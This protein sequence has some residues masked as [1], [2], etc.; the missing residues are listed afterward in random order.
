MSGTRFC[1]GHSCWC[2]WAGGQGP[3]VPRFDVFV[4][5]GPLMT[6]SP[7]S[8]KQHQS[9]WKP[10]VGFLQ[11]MFRSDHLQHLLGVYLPTALNPLDKL[12]QRLK[13]QHQRTPVWADPIVQIH[14]GAA[15]ISDYSTSWHCDFCVKHG[16]KYSLSKN[17]E[18][19]TCFDCES[20]NPC[21]SMLLHLLNISEKMAMFD[22]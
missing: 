8:L 14:C 3:L 4:K 15:C 7:P 2:S 16:A 19:K 22:G 13:R 6:L 21:P 5:T 11:R 17:K 9:I 18:M 12:N 1:T 20:G 10:F